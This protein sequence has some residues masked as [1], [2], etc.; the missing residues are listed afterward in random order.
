MT[1]ADKPATSG[2]RFR[3][4]LDVI[5]AV[6][7]VT[8]AAAVVWALVIRRPQS[9]AR[10]PTSDSQRSVPVPAE[11]VAIEGSPV[12]GDPA[13]PLAMIA[14][15][16]FECPFCGRFAKDVFPSIKTN[17]LQ[18]G[19]VKF[20]FKHLPLSDLHPR[21]ERAAAVAACAAMQGKFWA[22]HD[23]LFTDPKKL[24]DADLASYRKKVGL[25]DAQVRSCLNGE[26]KGRIDQDT[27]LAKAL[28]IRGT[29]TF[30]LGRVQGDGR[31]KV[32][33]VVAGALP[34]AEFSARLDEI[35]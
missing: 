20:V 27:A 3:T 1:T 28:S 29:P 24:E 17:Y 13:A 6:A 18:T 25:D 11:P 16:D 5:T 21:A 23:E 14:F 34:A 19:K 22:L 12:L 35:R 4:I 2:H 31:V 26:A 32:V 15:S 8:A 7:T 30:L 33:Q 9:V 10:S